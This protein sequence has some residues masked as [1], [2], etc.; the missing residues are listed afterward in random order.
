[1]NGSVPIRIFFYYFYVYAYT[2][3]GILYTYISYE[4]IQTRHYSKR[5]LII[6][7]QT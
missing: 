7:V 2:W 3:M 6:R 1:M 4:A 5:Y